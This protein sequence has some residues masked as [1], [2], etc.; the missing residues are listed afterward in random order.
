M[1]VVPE[2]LQIS[3][4]SLYFIPELEI[5]CWHR[6]HIISCKHMGTYTTFRKEFAKY[7][8]IKIKIDFEGFSC[9]RIKIDDAQYI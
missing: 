3:L 9:R 8:G 1:V 5:Q 4:Q 7:N 6:W 2:S